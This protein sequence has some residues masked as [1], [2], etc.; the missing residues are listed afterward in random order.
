MTH[1][2][3]DRLWKLAKRRAQFKQSLAIY[4]IINALEVGIWYFTSGPD[5]YFWP[6]WSLLGWGVAIAMQYVNAYHLGD[7]FSAEEEYKR[8]VDQ[9]DAKL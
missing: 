2:P 9:H 1:Q 5:T 4:V 8:L 7:T 6:F 3:D